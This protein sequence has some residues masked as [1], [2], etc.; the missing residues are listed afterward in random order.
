LE[1]PVNVLL[2]PGGPTVPE[3]AGLGVA[4]ISIGAAFALVAFDAVGE[5]VREL[6]GPGTLGFLERAAS[7]RKLAAAALQIDDAS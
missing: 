6:L 7:G 3:L 5:A 1:V 4:R 2:F